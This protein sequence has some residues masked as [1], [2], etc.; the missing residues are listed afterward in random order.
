[1]A[2]NELKKKGVLSDKITFISLIACDEGIQRIRKDHPEI[3]LLTAVIDPEINSQKY[4]IPG[5]GDY[6]D[7]YFASTGNVWL[8]NIYKWLYQSFNSNL[9]FIFFQDVFFMYFYIN[10]KIE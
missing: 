10:K 1:M 2:I 8:N 7:R 5:L 3:K 4:I 6:G 9:Y